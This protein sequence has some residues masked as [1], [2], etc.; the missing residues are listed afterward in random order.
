MCWDEAWS[1][2]QLDIEW[3]GMIQSINRP[4]LATIVSG[5]QG[6]SNW[7]EKSVWNTPLSIWSFVIQPLAWNFTLLSHLVEAKMV[8]LN[9]DYLGVNGLQ[10]CFKTPN[11]CHIQCTSS[12]NCLQLFWATYSLMK[13][14]GF[15]KWKLDK[16]WIIVWS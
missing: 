13:L 12:D 6:C 16:W 11:T 15:I 10:C 2:L 5:S 1:I 8:Q 9:Y 4:A 7:S 3:H 14:Y